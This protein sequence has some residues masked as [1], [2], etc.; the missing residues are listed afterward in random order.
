MSEPSDFPIDSVLGHIRLDIHASKSS[1]DINIMHE[2]TF[3]DPL[4][5][6]EYYPAARELVFVFEGD[7]AMSLGAPVDKGLVPFFLEGG[8]IGVFPVTDEGTMGKAVIVPLTVM[9]D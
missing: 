4:V 5:G 8:N 2:G 9:R 7:L 1:G 6:F 3:E